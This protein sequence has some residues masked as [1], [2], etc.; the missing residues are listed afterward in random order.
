MFINGNDKVK[1][2]PIAGVSI[3]YSMDN[4]T[5]ETVI[6]DD[7]HLVNN[8]AEF[9]INGVLFKVYAQRKKNFC[10]V[11]GQEVAV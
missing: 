6:A 10:A 11:N 8:V 7:R 4:N 9:T 1:L 5:D 2:N 3:A